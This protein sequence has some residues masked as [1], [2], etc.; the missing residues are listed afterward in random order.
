MKNQ[1]YKNST[2]TLVEVAKIAGVSRQTVSRILGSE[3]NKH[4]PETVKKVKEIA[5]SLGYRPN[6]L[7]KSIV[8]GKTNSIGILVPVINSLD[9]F[10][11]QVT[12]GIQ[13]ALIDTDIIPIFLHASPDAPEHHQI[14]RLV[15]RRVDG[16]ILIP[17]KTDVAPD[18]FC[19]ITYRR[20]PVVCVN[21][22]LTNIGAVDFVGTDEARGG[23][24]AAE[25]LLRM[26]HTNI[27]CLRWS[28]SSVNLGKRLQG[29]TKTI[30]EA[31]A[32]LQDIA[33][34]DWTIDGCM[35]TLCEAL[36]QPD[37]PS[38]FFCVSDQYAG[39][40]YKAAEKLGLTIPDDFSVLGFANLPWSEFLSPSLSTMSQDGQR[41]G[42]EAAKLLLSRIEGSTDRAKNKRVPVRL[43]QRDSVAPR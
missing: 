22:K 39:I 30:H 38:A 42:V 2:A 10:F 33:L 5:S 43:I 36:T 8:A 26:G 40:L 31:E 34:D 29:F 7:A 28:G 41:I 37:R 13:S 14:H 9:G 21:E 11:T 6:L 18:Y 32:R 20:I 24:I 25:Y 16:I 19:E 3:A 23:R 12:Y 27:G 1:T 4:K 17:Q 15:D 35:Q